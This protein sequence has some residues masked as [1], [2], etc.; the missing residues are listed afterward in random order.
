MEY[1]QALEDLQPLQVIPELHNRVSGIGLQQLL[2]VDTP[3]ELE[4]ILL[5]VL[6]AR[7][8]DQD[9]LELVRDQR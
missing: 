6:T 9:P 1:Q 3:Q 5:V 4:Q 7:L 2:V 8:L